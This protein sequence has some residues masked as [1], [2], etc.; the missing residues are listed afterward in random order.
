MAVRLD[1]V[2]V[3]VVGI[4]VSEK[5]VGG[6]PISYEVCKGEGADA[7]ARFVKCRLD[8]S[9]PSGGATSWIFV[10]VEYIVHEFKNVVRVE[11]RDEVNVPG[12]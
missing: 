5:A 7:A 9:R 11:A 2:T 3:S 12:A 8:R 4:F 10:Y 6:A 1:D